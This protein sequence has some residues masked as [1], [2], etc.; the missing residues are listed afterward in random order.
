M[1]PMR[2]NLI[3]TVYTGQLQ[4]LYFCREVDSASV[5]GGSKSRAPNLGLEYFYM[6]IYIN[7]QITACIY[8]CIYIYCVYIYVDQRT[9]KWIYIWIRPGKWIYMW[10]RPGIWGTGSSLYSRYIYNTESL[11]R[12]DPDLDPAGGFQ[13]QRYNAV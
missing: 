12:V 8:M 11:A 1:A 13:I 10:I 7:I 6:H 4:G 3:S 2:I 5:A 9:L